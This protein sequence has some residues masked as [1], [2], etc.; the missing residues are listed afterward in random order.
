MTER[1]GYSVKSMDDVLLF[2]CGGIYTQ[3]HPSHFIAMGDLGDLV[4]E[5]GD[6]ERCISSNVIKHQH[7]WYRHIANCPG[8]RCTRKVLQGDH[9]LHTVGGC[10]EDLWIKLLCFFNGIWCTESEEMFSL[11]TDRECAIHMVIYLNEKNG[12]NSATY[13]AFPRMPWQRFGSFLRR[14][15]LHVVSR[16][17]AIAWSMRS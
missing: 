8:P 4:T 16:P 2:S 13:N 3:L 14:P 11:R 5:M 10:S 7:W 6:D 12:G 15:R 17:R 1:M 9:Y